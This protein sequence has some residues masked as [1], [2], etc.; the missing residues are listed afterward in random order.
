MYLHFYFIVRQKRSIPEYDSWDFPAFTAP[1]Y[2][3]AG[4]EVFYDI[5]E[6][7]VSNVPALNP[8]NFTTKE[9]GGVIF[10]HAD[11]STDDL[12][13]LAVSVFFFFFFCI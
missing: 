7:T 4:L 3:S 12:S 9:N 10:V 5:N 6:T 2:A 8:S 13:C 1:S 11:A